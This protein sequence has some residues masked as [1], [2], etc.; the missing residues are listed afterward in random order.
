MLVLALLGFTKLRDKLAD[1]SKTQTI[2]SPRKHPFKVG[3]RLFI[4]WKLRTKNCE[5]L[6][7]GVVTSVVR[8]RYRDITNED[9]V[10]DGFVD[11]MSFCHAFEELHPDLSSESEFDILTWEWTDKRI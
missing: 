11:I 1:G 8:K 7:E 3:E 5:K 6:G 4:Y 9:A 2:R 10:R